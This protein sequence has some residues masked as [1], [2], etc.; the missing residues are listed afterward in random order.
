MTGD[1]DGITALI[2]VLSTAF[3]VV[4][5][6]AV[7]L[8]LANPLAVIDIHCDIAQIA[9]DIEGSYKDEA[10]ALSTAAQSRDLYQE[11]TRLGLEARKCYYL[12]SK[13]DLKKAM[14]RTKS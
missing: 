8:N 10:D 14:A 5:K 1:Y 6:E 13:R 9:Q 12:K 11:V 4:N 3:A 2:D 7:T